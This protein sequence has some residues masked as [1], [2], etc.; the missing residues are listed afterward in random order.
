M[1]PALADD[2]GK[3]FLR[4]RKAIDQF[5]IPGGLLDWI[6]IAPLHIFD[7][8]DLERLGIAELANNHRH[9]VQL[10]ALRCAPAPL[11]GNNLVAVVASGGP[12]EDWLQHALFRNRFSQAG[13]FFLVEMAP[14]LKR[15]WLEERH[16]YHPCADGVGT[17]AR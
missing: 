16:R 17:G 12:H 4:V 3:L 10:R 6:E 9:I 13:K 8:G 14:G 2:T 11:A 15:I 7:D 5:L 1:A